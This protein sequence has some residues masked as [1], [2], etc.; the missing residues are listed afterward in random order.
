MN[1]RLIPASWQK[2]LGKYGWR[3]AIGLALT[4]AAALHPG[5]WL[6]LDVVDRMDSGIAGLRMRLEPAHLEPRIVIVD[7]DSKSLTEIGRFPW[8]RNIHAQLVTTLFEKYQ[9]ATLGYD[10]S[11]PEPDTSSGFNVL[12]RLSRTELQ[13][14]RLLRDKL[15]SLRPALDYDGLFG[16]AMQGL[17]VILGF[18][19]SPDQKKG[20][21]PKP[22]FTSED[23][24]GREVLAYNA[25]GYEANIAR[26][27]RFAGGAGSFS[28]VTDNDGLVRT[29]GLIQQVGEAYYPSLSLAVAASYLKATAIKPVLAE[30]ADTMSQSALA[31]GGYDYVQIYLPRQPNGPIRSLPIPVGEGMTINIQYRGNGWPGGGAFR[32]V[33]ATDVLHGRVPAA[34]LKG[35]IVLVG[36]TAAGLVDL[37]ATPVNKEFPGVEIHANIIKSILDQQ[38]KVRH[39][40]AWPIETLEILLVGLLM[41][42]LLATL[43]P[44]RAV[45]ATG[46]ALLAIIGLNSYEYLKLDLLFNMSMPL[47][48]V[49]S[50][51]LLNQAWGYFFEVRKGKALVNR[52]GE[53]VAP[54]LVE[55][56]A[57]DPD[58]YNMDGESRE[59]TVMFVDVRGFT[60]ISEGLSPKELRE[61]INIYL[62]AM[63]EDIRSAYRGTLDKYIG[64][65]VMA[66]WGAPVP[67]ADHAARGVATALLMQASAHRLNAEFIARGWP[68]LKIGIGVN[69]GMMHVGDMGSAIRKAYTVM[70]DAVNLASRLEG[71][72][73]VYGV[74]I[75]CGENTAHAATDFVYRELDLV[76]VKGKHEP[77]AIFEPV[78]KASELGPEV[79]AEIGRWHAALALVRQ[80][81]WDEAERSLHALQA[82]RPCGLYQLFLERI[83]VYREDPP[84][85]DWDGVTK[86]ETK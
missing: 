75:C 48:L 38:F 23:L 19:L 39:Y 13:D 74:G 37:R 66:F 63:S 11:F 3:W 16:N 59:L 35:A 15:D 25:E 85:A 6:P 20:V 68:E 2:T 10:V 64:D 24:N 17:P 76:R 44:L 41:A 52:F 31:A 14:D 86:F 71:I 21:L 18:S 26:L 56:M 60:T 57:E 50:L 28:V 51:F 77:V 82:E 67:F 45:A 5:G 36:T 46:I 73:K 62:T 4:L 30:A 27:Q 54:E 69:S 61:Y 7:I 72:T 32:Y 9:I 12:D 29:A 55:V 22:L 49:F 40:L 43:A 81:R 79:I 83:A 47:L 1:V 84:G 80:Q 33:S 65:A 70:G 58:K 34:Q 53:Y 42:I 78:G 8:S